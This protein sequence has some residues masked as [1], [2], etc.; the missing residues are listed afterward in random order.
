MNSFHWNMR[1]PD[2]VDVKGIYHSSFA[3]AKPLGPEVMPGK[4]YAVLSYGHTA[5]K[6][7]FD[8][9][10]D[11]RLDTPQAGLQ[12]RFD[13]L[14]RIHDAMNN[15]SKHLNQAI[16]T[17]SA[18]QKEL[19]KNSVDADAASKAVA[20]LSNDIES[21]VNLKIQSGEG[22]LVYAPQL[23]AW[24][25][26]I[27]DQASFAFVKPTPAMEEVANMYI[28]ES[29]QAVTHLQAD[30]KAANALLKK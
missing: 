7:S 3:A 21:L 24:L 1:Y 23:R 16:D 30:T 8:V 18:L 25:S 28:T 9:K 5:Q 14:M 17:R 4:Y 11:P 15:V 29:Q 12:E 27:S 10:L 20:T 13:L 19:H 6:Q 22:A 26:A 2:A